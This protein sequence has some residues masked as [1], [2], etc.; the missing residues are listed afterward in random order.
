[1]VNMI[2][3]FIINIL[4]HKYNA[5]NGTIKIITAMK[6]VGKTYLLFTLFYNYLISIG[7]EE[8]N[9][10]R[11]SFEDYDNRHLFKE[12]NLYKAISE[13]IEKVLIKLGQKVDK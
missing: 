11:I 7:I 1:M 9:I 5:K 4:K 3:N 8:S 12:E 13:K 6:R 10:L 2:K